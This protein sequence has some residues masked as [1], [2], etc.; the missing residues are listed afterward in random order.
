VYLS[1]ID[2]S[3]NELTGNLDIFGSWPILSKMNFSNNNWEEAPLPMWLDTLENLNSFICKTCNLK[4]G[5]PAGF[6][7][8]DNLVHEQIVLD[9][10]D[11]GG[12]VAALFIGPNSTKRLYLSIWNN[13]FSGSFPTHLIHSAS[14]VDIRG[15]NYTDIT[16]FPDSVAFDGRFS[17][18]FN[19]F[20]YEALESVQEYI[21]LDGDLEVRYGNMRKTLTADTLTITE[22]TTVTLLAGDLHPNTTYEWVGPTVQ[23][24][25]DPM[26][27]YIID[28]FANGGTFRCIMN[29]ESF[30]DLALTRNDVV[31]RVDL[32]TTSTYEVLIDAKV[33]PNPTQDYLIIELAD[34]YQTGTYT[35]LRNDGTKVRTG[36]IN[37]SQSIEIHDLNSGVYFLHVRSNDHILTQPI[38]KL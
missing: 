18:E 7:L 38:I 20:N 21:E 9:N 15:N 2:I 31:I 28:E 36:S 32:N 33:F 25:T 16:A 27:D 26:V 14:S 23:G 37:K 17:T 30:P 5:I 19:K 24:L 22:P 6:D 10:N 34:Q 4:G 1:N 3:D 8:R 35:L 12:D 29:N 11:L 13:G